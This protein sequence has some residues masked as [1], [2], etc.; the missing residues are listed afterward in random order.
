MLVRDPCS[1]TSKSNVENESFLEQIQLEPSQIKLETCLKIHQ[2]K[3]TKDQIDM[4]NQSSQESIQIK[5]NEPRLL[6]YD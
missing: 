3:K 2:G 4:A 1:P 5:I 6:I